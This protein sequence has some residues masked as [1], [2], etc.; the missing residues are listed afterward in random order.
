MDS[1]PL[2][3]ERAPGPTA[4]GDPTFDQARELMQSLPPGY[5]WV[6]IALFA[7]LVVLI[8]GV[9]IAILRY[10]VARLRVIK[11]AGEGASKATLDAVVK[12]RDHLAARV[13]HLERVVSS[14]DLDLHG[15]IERLA[16]RQA[17]LQTL[18]S[19]PALGDGT[20]ALAEAMTVAVQAPRGELPSGSLVLDRFEVERALGRGG[21]GA[22]YLA[23][24][25][26]LGERVALKVIS[27]EL[28]EDPAAVE[29]FRR[30]VNA[31]RKVTHSNVIRIHDLGSDAGM[32]FLT[33]EYFA[34]RSLS[35]V[36]RQRHRLTL[37]EAVPLVEQVC[38]GLEAAHAAGIVHRDLKPQNVLVNERGEVRVI[39]FGLA[40][41]GYLETMT[42]TGYMMGT[43][44]YMAPEQVRGRAVDARADI[45]AL[46]AMTYHTLC[47]RPPFTADSPIAVGFMHCSEAPRPPRELQPDLPAGAE[48][49]ILKALA[50]EPRDRFESVS[51][52]RRALI[53]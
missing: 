43:P 25:R 29:R 39:D 6:P 28:A 44:E 7:G 4:V 30:E 15:R 24:D 27:H 53:A 26:Q 14:L 13:Q 11:Q 38:A 32:L 35:E 20:T 34:G 46:G 18:A 19:R 22:V 36:L 52:F 8:L 2:G 51:E 40:K 48:A 42:A 50:K 21:M 45:Y 3:M 41:A 17:A 10:R 49:A 31:A 37:D 9:V 47:G 5:Q 16:D 12:E 23:R 33:M 1:T